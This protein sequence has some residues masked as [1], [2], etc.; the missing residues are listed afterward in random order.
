M[1]SIHS[2]K[3]EGIEGKEIDFAPFKGKKLIIIN[4]ASECGCTPPYQQL[5]E[6]Y[7]CFK[8]KVVIVGFP[9]NDF[10][11][12]EP[13]TNEEIQAFC[14]RRYGVTFPLATKIYI[15]GSSVHPVYQWLTQQ[16]QNGVADSEVRWNFHKYLLDEHGQLVKSLPSDVSPLDEQILDWLNS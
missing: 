1:H 3:V 15:K 16:T 8:D 7:E 12:Q 2:F 9:S 13:G 14:N 5:Q 4:V 6:L 11:G 10:G